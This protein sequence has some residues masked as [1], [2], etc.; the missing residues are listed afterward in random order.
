VQP[1]IDGAGPLPDSVIT[2]EVQEQV[3]DVDADW[4]KI[5]LVLR[6]DG[7]SADVDL[8]HSAQ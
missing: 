7:E 4:R 2:P 6:K 3:D 1:L 5:H 8:D